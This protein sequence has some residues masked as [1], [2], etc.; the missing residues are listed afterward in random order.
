MGEIHVD[1]TIRN[2]AQ[3]DSCWEGN[4]LVDTGATDTQVPRRHLEAIG[5]EPVGSGVYVLADGSEADLDVTNAGIE[6]M[7]EVL[8]GR[9]IYGEADAEPLLG[10]TA[11]ESAGLEVD[12]RNQT[13]KRRRRRL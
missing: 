8:A 13:L 9:I 5:L 1:V 7:G 2:L 4:F 6:F 10:L 12:P 3:P 11:L